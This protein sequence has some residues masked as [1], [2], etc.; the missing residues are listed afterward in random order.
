M[1]WFG[2][3]PGRQ[4]GLDRRPLYPTSRQPLARPPHPKNA[5]TSHSVTAYQGNG[6]YKKGGVFEVA[7]SPNLTQSSKLSQN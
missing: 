3:R 2:F 4:R 6:F 1:S 7:G 5:M